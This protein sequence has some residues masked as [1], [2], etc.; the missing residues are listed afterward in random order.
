M[1]TTVL[2]ICASLI[3]GYIQYRYGDEDN[4]PAIIWVYLASPFV[5][6][7]IVCVILFRIAGQRTKAET[8]AGYTTRTSGYA[9]F[10]QVDP[11]TGVVVRAAGSA[12]LTLPSK[13]DEPVSASTEQADTLR[14]T[15]DLGMRRRWILIWVLSPIVLVITFAGGWAQAGGGTGGDLVLAV[16]VG[17]LVVIFATVFV[18][19]GLYM[20]VYLRT[21]AN[22]DPATFVFLSRTTPEFVAAA[23][24]IGLTPQTGKY[25]GVAITAAGL[26][27]W[28]R[29]SSAGPFAKLGWSAI[30]RV[31]PARLLISSGQTNVP[32]AT[33]HVFT[34]WNGEDLDLPLPVFGP[35]ALGFASVADANKVLDVVAQHARIA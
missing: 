13:G 33:L 24:S 29:K 1:V 23:G 8:N 27:F 32:A 28:P 20:R 22:G 35:R 19:V 10:D 4:P 5:V 31:Q 17:S 12:V 30:K 21:A 14:F 34:P 16:S 15:P 26:E 25:F 3:L 2:T 11:R 6:D 18:S 7:I 9:A